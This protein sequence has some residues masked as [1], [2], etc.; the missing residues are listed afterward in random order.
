MSRELSDK[1]E[2]PAPPQMPTSA[3][4]K[5]IVMRFWVCFVFKDL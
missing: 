5:Q 4:G 1:T 2:K 3:E